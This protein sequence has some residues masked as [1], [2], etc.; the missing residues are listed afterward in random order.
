[1]IHVG[2]SV[3][4]FLLLGEWLAVHALV[5]TAHDARKMLKGWREQ[6]VEVEGESEYEYCES[7][8]GKLKVGEF[9][10]QQRYSLSMSQVRKLCASQHVMVQGRPV[11]YNHVLT[12]ADRVF[13]TA[14]THHESI[15]GPT[16]SETSENTLAKLVKLSNHLYLPRQPTV[17]FEDDHM[18][19]VVK[20]AGI[21]TLPWAG[22]DRAKFTFA[23]IL[24]LLVTAP[25]QG[26]GL[27]SPVPVHRLDARVSGLV[28][29]AKTKGALLA[30][31]DKFRS[32]SAAALDG[33]GASV[34][35]RGLRKWYKAC[36]RGTPKT[37]ALK[38]HPDGSYEIEVALTKDHLHD[39]HCTASDPS[40]LA[41]AAAQELL[42]SKSLLKVLHVH[43][44][45]NKR[46]CGQITTVLLSPMTG[47]RHQ[48]RRHTASLGSPILGDNLYSMA[49]ARSERL[50]KLYLQSV[51]VELQHPV[52]PQQT[53][54]ASLLEYEGAGSTDIFRRLYES[55]KKTLQW[56]KNASRG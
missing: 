14:A 22:I 51:L 13:V 7:E 4:L 1:M 52:L 34:S 10:F 17:M 28:I 30:L 15:V 6:G 56:E 25:S 33:G 35:E 40:S 55:E 37:D 24:P 45:S 21:H 32:E 29:V 12:D 48:L 39:P 26:A 8:N 36:L 9:L 42:E 5:L 23:D 50:G 43:P 18:A 19:I 46:G 44:A 47:R 53:V 31:N 38:K 54:R 11:F 20:P 41:P 16:R 27:P 2:L 3:G 49:E